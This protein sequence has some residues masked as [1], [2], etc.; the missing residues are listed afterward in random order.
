MPA[1]SD[2][3]A[4]IDETLN[5]SGVPDYPNALNGI[6][7]ANRGQIQRVAVAV[8]FSTATIRG[9]IDAGAQLL[10][11][12]HGMFWGGAQTITAHRYERLR[13]LFDHD[14]AVY[15]AH[16]SSRRSSGDWQQRTSCR[17]SRP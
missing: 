5:V 16:L 7:V 4:F 11:V 2:V 6:Q 13:L 12:H 15:S 10:L 8:D 17:C 1:L 9:A 3:A 14:I